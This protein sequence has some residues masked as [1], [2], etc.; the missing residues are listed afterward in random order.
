[1][2]SRQNEE[3]SIAAV[4][5]AITPNENKTEQRNKIN[6]CHMQKYILMSLDSRTLSRVAYYSSFIRVDKKVD[7][8]LA[9]CFF[10]WQFTINFLLI[11]EKI[12]QKDKG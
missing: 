4:I 1:M 10:Y 6:N 12:Q 3:I 2:W 5:I 11:T 9:R 8:K 7:K